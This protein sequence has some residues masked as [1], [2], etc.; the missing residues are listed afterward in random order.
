M[1][2]I[3]VLLGSRTT[4]ERFCNKPGHPYCPD[5]QREMDAMAQADK[6]WDEVFASLKA[7]C[8]DPKEEK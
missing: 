2:C 3:W 4:D 1:A 8:E 5:H 6:D 7:V